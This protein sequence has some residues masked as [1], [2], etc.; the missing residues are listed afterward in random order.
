MHFRFALDPQEWWDLWDRAL[1]GDA[2]AAEGLVVSSPDRDRELEDAL[3]SMGGGSGPAASLAI[4]TVVSYDS[5]LK[6]ATVTIGGVPGTYPV[7]IGN[8]R[9][10]AG[11]TVI[12]DQTNGVA[13][14]YR[15]S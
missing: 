10:Y 13:F 15:R 3:G 1:G 7:Y 6:E 9:L 5:V 4:G 8:R 14:G 11:N 2:A 12:V